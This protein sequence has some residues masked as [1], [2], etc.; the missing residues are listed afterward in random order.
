MAISRSI[1]LPLS[2]IGCL[3]DGGAR[4]RLYLQAQHAYSL[5]TEKL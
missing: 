2:L 1:L 5:V 4:P 3:T